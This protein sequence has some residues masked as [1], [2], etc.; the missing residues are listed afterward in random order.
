MAAFAGAAGAGGHGAAETA[1]LK[2]NVQDQMNRLLQQLTDLEELRSEL[3]DEEYAEVRKDTLDQI[4]E[5]DAQLKRLLEGDM[6]LVSELGQIKLALEAAIRSAFMTP[7]VIRMFAR[8]EP[9]A[10]RL[11]LA[12][13]HEDHKLGR[14]AE[15]AFRQQ[16]VEVIVALKKLGE[17]VGAGAHAPP[18]PR[19]L[20]RRL[21]G[22]A[23]EPQSGCTARLTPLRAAIAVD[24]RGAGLL[25][26]LH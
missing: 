6:T 4:A 2:A 22:C 8:R 23:V 5:F 20:P 18:L 7:E 17:E 14:L 3:E 19:P 10:L 24:D 13:L 26:H 15:H 16:A 1:S 25:V 9:S 21:R 12:K 11:R